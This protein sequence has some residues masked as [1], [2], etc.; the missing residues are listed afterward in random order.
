MLASGTQNRGFEPGRNRRIFQAKNPQHVF[1]RRESK[2]VCL[3]SQLCDRLQNPTTTW[4]SH[5]LG[6]I[7][8]AMSRPHFLL[9]LIEVSHA[10]WHG[11]PLE[12]NGETNTGFS[13]I[14]LERLQCV[15]RDSASP[16]ERRR[17]PYGV[18]LKTG[19]QVN[20]LKPFCIFV[21]Q[22][23]IKPSQKL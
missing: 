11:A 3:L 10:V 17:R 21:A 8:P 23:I 22:I 1:L 19:A 12:M 7:W 9:S 14:S 13:T 4:K 16:T 18:K 2:A 20:W 15:R 5:L 6:Y